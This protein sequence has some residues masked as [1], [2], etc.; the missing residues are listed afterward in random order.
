MR[1]CILL[2]HSIPNLPD[3]LCRDRNESVLGGFLL[4]LALETELTPRLRLN[5]ERAFLPVE[6]SVLGVLHFGVTH[7]RIQEQTIEQFF[8]FIHDRKHRLEFLL[9]LRL[10]RLLSV[11]K[12]SQDL[13]GNKNVP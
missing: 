4:A 8:F 11:V 12:F 3:E 9:R 1:L 13:A 6:V 5:M 10:Q 7:T 2:S